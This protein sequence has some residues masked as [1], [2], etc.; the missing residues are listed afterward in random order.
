[1]IEG[2]EGVTWQQWR[3]LAARSEV[4][5][6]PALFRPDPHL[7]PVG[8]PNP[9]AT[10]HFTAPDPLRRIALAWR[11]SFPR[12]RAVQAVRE[13]LLACKL[14]GVTLLPQAKPIEF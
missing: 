4:P 3:A 5:G 14:P 11:K 9:T 12:A 8:P 6:I 10:K 13:S 7:P 1:M 2:Q